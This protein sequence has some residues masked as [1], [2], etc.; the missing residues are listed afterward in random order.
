MH[1][2]KCVISS[3]PMK[4]PTR[5][6]YPPSELITLHVIVALH[7]SSHSN[8]CDKCAAGHEYHYTMTTHTHSTVIVVP[9]EITC[10]AAACTSISVDSQPRTLL[11]CKLITC[12]LLLNLQF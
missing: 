3:F 10:R 4:M 8:Q 11:D 6:E 7:Y 9:L 5:S 1:A 12:T 2:G